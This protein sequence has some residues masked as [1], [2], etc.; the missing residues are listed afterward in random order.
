MALVPFVQTRHVASLPACLNEAGNLS[1]KGKLPQTDS[2]HAKSPEKG[3]GATTQRA[4]VILAH[5]KLR[6]ALGFDF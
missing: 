2:T 5:R 6:P 1:L 4:A 3:S